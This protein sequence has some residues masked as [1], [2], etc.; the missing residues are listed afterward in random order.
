[1]E[2]EVRPFIRL[3]LKNFAE[4]VEQL[5]MQTQSAQ[6]E[7]ENAQTEL[8]NAY[9]TLA[10]VETAAAKQRD[11]QLERIHELEKEKTDQSTL[12]SQMVEEMDSQ[13]QAL[14]KHEQELQALRND[15]LT[16]KK[17]CDKQRRLREGLEVENL[18][19]H[20]QL[21]S[22]KENEKTLKQRIS[23]LQQETTCLWKDHPGT[24]RKRKGG[25]PEG[26]TA[27]FAS[28]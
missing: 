13:Q 25:S 21:N 3:T 19:L 9:N 4:H 5:Q 22:A 1:M 7:K 27:S 26:L 17:N 18:S 14:D 16:A 6:R 2:A 24:T 23:D 15:L 12:T 20:H 10:T 8:N 11:T 28:G